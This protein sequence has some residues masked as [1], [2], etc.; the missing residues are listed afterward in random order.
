MNRRYRPERVLTLF[1][2]VWPRKWQSLDVLRRG[3]GCALGML[4]DPDVGAGGFAGAGETRPRTI[5]FSS[6]Q[7][8]QSFGQE[9][10]GINP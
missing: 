1:N 5:T 9:P 10:S 2:Q 6:W 8:W 7:S 3:V 4:S